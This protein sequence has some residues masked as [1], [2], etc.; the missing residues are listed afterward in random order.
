MTENDQVIKISFLHINIQL[1]LVLSDFNM[2]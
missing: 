1:Y 2:I